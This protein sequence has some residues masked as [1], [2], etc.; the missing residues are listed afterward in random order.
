[1]TAKLL[2][3]QQVAEIIGEHPRTTLDRI[4][5]GELPAINKGSDKP[6][7]ARWRIEPAA[8]DRWL[9]ARRRTGRAA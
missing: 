2:T 1:M 3:R 6:Y 8:L 7:G 4:L 9:K 5:R